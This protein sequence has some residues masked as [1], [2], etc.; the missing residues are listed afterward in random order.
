MTYIVAEAG[1]NHGGDMGR[2]KELI[3]RSTMAGADYVKFQLY[4]ADKLEPP[5]K[6]RDLLET[7]QLS[8]GDMVEL[9]MECEQYGIRFGCTAFD[10]DSARFLLHELEPAFIKIAS[11]CLYQELI[12]SLEN[13]PLLVMSTG[14]ASLAHIENALYWRK[15]AT[16][17]NTI[18][19]HCVSAYPTPW[20][21]M[22][23]RVIDTL[24][25]AFRLPVGLSDHSLGDAAAVVAA[26]MEAEMIEKHIRLDDD[27]LTPDAAVSLRPIEFRGMVERCHAASY[28][29]GNSRKLIHQIEVPTIQTIERRET[30]R[31]GQKTQ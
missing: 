12:E 4:R 11:G 23:L 30:Y 21:D 19:L 5:G 1:I 24:R 18:L 10:P 9:K 7:C 2:A 13:A 14:M 20:G 15:G 22:N 16:V 29:M 25:S 6:T 26:S 31:N 28:V 3:E 27:A 17:D 8:R